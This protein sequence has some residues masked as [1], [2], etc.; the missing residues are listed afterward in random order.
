MTIRSL[1]EYVGTDTQGKNI[2]VGDR[3]V[4][5]ALRQ[6]DRMPDWAWTALGAVGGAALTFAGGWAW[7]YWYFN[8]NNP[9]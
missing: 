8:R 9:M 6:G 4:D 7:L 5:A 1:L 2:Y 3:L